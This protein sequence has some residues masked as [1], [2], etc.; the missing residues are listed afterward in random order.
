MTYAST[1]GYGG[2][3]VYNGY[4]EIHE[5]GLTQESCSFASRICGFFLNAA[6]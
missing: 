4:R 3:Y 1:H 6:L 5:A 2:S